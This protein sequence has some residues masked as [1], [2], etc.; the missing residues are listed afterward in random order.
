MNKGRSINK[1]YFNVVCFIDNCSM[2]YV[3]VL[4]VRLYIVGNSSPGNYSGHGL[5]YSY[6]KT[7]THFTRLTR[8]GVVCMTVHTHCVAYVIGFGTPATILHTAIPAK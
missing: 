4:E 6:K 3:Y 2:M 7:W 8:I 5:V 1:I